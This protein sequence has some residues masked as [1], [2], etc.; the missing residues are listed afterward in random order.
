MYIEQGTASRTV[1][2]TYNPK[3]G[4]ALRPLVQCTM[5]RMQ[6]NFGSKL[7][8]WLKPVTRKHL[9]TSKA[10]TRAIPKRQKRSRRTDICS[11][12]EK[13]KSDI[14]CVRDSLQCVISVWKC[15][16]KY[17]KGNHTN[18]PKARVRRATTSSRYTVSSI[19]NPHAGLTY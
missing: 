5:L 8:N 14:A 12:C 3:Q 4:T 15:I 10:S 7:K 18:Q 1:T 2:R 9:A 13:R 19:P 6:R 11:C 17:D 16:R